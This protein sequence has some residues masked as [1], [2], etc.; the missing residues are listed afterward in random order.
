MSAS[1]SITEKWVLYPIYCHLNTKY[2]LVSLSIAF[3][4]SATIQYSRPDRS[5]NRDHELDHNTVTVSSIFH[6]THP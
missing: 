5:P 2:T 6:H 1:H 4:R 3:Y